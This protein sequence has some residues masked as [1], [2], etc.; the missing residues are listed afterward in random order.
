M[1][2]MT[3]SV[4]SLIALVSLAGCAKVQVSDRESLVSKQQG[5]ADAIKAFPRREPESRAHPGELTASVV[6][7]RARASWLQEDRTWTGCS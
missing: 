3:G 6:P 4:L 2:R 1:R 5:R 7:G